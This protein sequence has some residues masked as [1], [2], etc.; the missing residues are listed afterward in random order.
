MA[1]FHSFINYLLNNYSL[2]SSVLG[3]RDVVFKQN[4]HRS[5]LVQ[6]IVQVEDVCI[7]MR[8]HEE[9]FETSAHGWCTGMTQRDGMGREV[10]GGSG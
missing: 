3:T 4:R 2:L 7:Y 10:G 5:C 9:Y 6:F 1:L 8:S